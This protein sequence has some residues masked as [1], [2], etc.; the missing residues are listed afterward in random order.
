MRFKKIGSLCLCGVLAFSMAGCGA[1]GN[2]KENVQEQPPVE[3]TAPVETPEVTP[4]VVP[5][6]EEEV[7]EEVNPL[8]A[9]MQDYLSKFL[10]AN[11]DGSGIVDMIGIFNED[12]SYIEH[13]RYYNDALLC[14]AMM[15]DSVFG[16]IAKATSLEVLEVETISRGI[17]KVSVKNDLGN[18]FVLNVYKQN[19]GYLVDATHLFVPAKLNITR[20]VVGH[21]NGVQL[22]ENDFGNVENEGYAVYN[23]P[24]VL[25]NIENVMK[26]DTGFSSPF[27][28]SFVVDAKTS[29]VDLFYNLTSNDLAVII[30]NI[31]KLWTSLHT[32]ALENNVETISGLLS[33][34]SPLNANMVIEGHN[35]VKAKFTLKEFT[36]REGGKCIL[37]STTRMYLDLR[38]VFIGN[39]SFGTLTPSKF[40]NITVDIQEDGT[41]KVHDASTE[42][43]LNSDI[44]A[45][46]ND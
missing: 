5:P 13:T 38:G 16:N 45:Y 44:N 15:K 20:G 33:E 30:P 10:Q 26:Y 36:P 39:Y 27:E 32:L 3:Q 18:E 25:A 29:E 40:N 8:V 28:K 2:V 42:I 4:E 34:D 35:A 12:Y 7:V 17:Y 37:Y 43:W 24:Y 23:I 9:E 14:K 6:V 41:Y 19:E 31:S 22:S 21:L 1:V 46:S 11:V